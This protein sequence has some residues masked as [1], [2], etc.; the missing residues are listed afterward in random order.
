MVGKQREISVA[1]GQRMKCAD[2]TARN[3]AFGPIHF[4]AVDMEE[5][6]ML[7]FRTQHAL[8]S[9]GKWEFI[10]CVFKRMDLALGWRMGGKRFI[11][12]ARTRVDVWGAE[13]PAGAHA[14]A[15]LCSNHIGSPGTIRE[16]YLLPTSRDAVNIGH[17]RIFKKLGWLLNDIS[18]MAR[19]FASEFTNAKKYMAPKV[20]SH[21]NIAMVET[22]NLSADQLIRF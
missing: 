1:T 9:E 3:I 7:N 8:G 14:Q 11:I 20:L 19:S 10:Q 2:Y 5:E 6:V 13:L 22:S 16:L 17:G 15:H 21:I 18:P 12:P 4:S